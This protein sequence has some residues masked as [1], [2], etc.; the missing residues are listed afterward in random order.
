MR[1]YAERLADYIQS[2]FADIEVF[3]DT[4]SGRIL[5]G[6]GMKSGIAMC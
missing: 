6:Q 4:N 5:L 2:V 3:W 1:D